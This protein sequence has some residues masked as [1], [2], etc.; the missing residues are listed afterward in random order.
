[1]RSLFAS[2][3][4]FL[5]SATAA[6]A[7]PAISEPWV[8]LVPGNSTAAGYVTLTSPVNDALTVAASDCCDAVEI[9]EM[10]IDNDVMRMREVDEIALP[11]GENV[12]LAPMGYHL[13][14]MG[15]DGELGPSVPITLTFASGATAT[16][17]FPVKRVGAAASHTGHEGHH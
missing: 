10:R 6:L 14:L 3:A 12:T 1:M 11:A 17:D 4:F 7:A 16:V 8:R 5:A 2:F 9:H 15:I 13:M